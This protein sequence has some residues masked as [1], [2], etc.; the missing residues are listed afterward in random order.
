MARAVGTLLEFFFFNF[1][2]R[3]FGVR[4]TARAAALHRK[5]MGQ[6]RL[7][8]LRARL[9]NPVGSIQPKVKTRLRRSIDKGL[10]RLASPGQISQALTGGPVPPAPG[11]QRRAQGRPSASA[12]LSGSAAPSLRGQGALWRPETTRACQA[13]QG[14]LARFDKPLPDLTSSDWRAGA[15]PWAAAQGAGAPKRVCWPLW[16]RSALPL[17]PGRALAP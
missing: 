6:L 3:L 15:A 16:G 13:W 17:R 9:S 11:Q 14:S 1:S 4:D 7:R 8:N 2:I 5:P 10:S 12:G